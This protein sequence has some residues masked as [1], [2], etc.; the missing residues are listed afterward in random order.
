MKASLASI[1]ASLEV[2][3]KVL[4]DIATSLQR[5]NELRRASLSAEQRK[6]LE[7]LDRAKAAR[8]IKIP[9]RPS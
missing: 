1:A 2:Q 4:Q 7:T 6:Y 5:T 3:T 8:M 9:P